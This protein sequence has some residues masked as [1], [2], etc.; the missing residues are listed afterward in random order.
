MGPTP[1]GLSSTDLVPTLDYTRS[2]I[3][4]N[5][6]YFSGPT[7]KYG[8]SIRPRSPYPGMMDYDSDGSFPGAPYTTPEHNAE[9][10]A[11]HVLR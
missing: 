2:L 8:S 3:Q 1:R 9:H 6:D 7:P 10:V 5:G 4:P 11:H